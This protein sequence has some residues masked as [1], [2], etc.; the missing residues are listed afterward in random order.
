MNRLK[1]LLAWIK[2][3]LP[4]LQVLLR[5]VWNVL[6]HNW[7]FKLL[8]LVMAAVLWAGLISQDE[9]L[10]IPKDMDP[11]EI[12]VQGEQ[13]LRSRG[14][15]ITAGD[16]E[17]L[18]AAIRADVPQLKYQDAVGG[19]YNPRIDLSRISRPG[20]YT[21]DVTTTD[22]AAWGSVV[23]VSP[24][25]VSLTVESIDTRYVSV[26]TAVD[27]SLPEGWCLSALKPAV[28]IVGVRGPASVVSQV[29]SLVAVIDLSEVDV[30]SIRASTPGARSV[31]FTF[32]DADG[33]LID[34]GLLEVLLNSAVSK[35]IPVTYMLNR[36]TD[37]QLKPESLWTGTP[38]AGYAVQSVSPEAAFTLS[39]RRTSVFTASERY[40]RVEPLSVEGATGDVTGTV[41]VTLETGASFVDDQVVRDDNFSGGASEA[42]TV[43]VHIAPVEDT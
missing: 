8:A 29:G 43:T 31:G 26:I 32:A 7:I 17:G 42:F 20:E 6:R 12:Q 2:Q 14:L 40:Y 41:F 39:G 38:A 28:D 27:G 24:A 10:N 1:P 30:G 5:A 37:V 15:V 36:A 21:L 23:S 13:T 11:V 33:V 19:N 22:S 3:Q 4:R 25:S 18:Q 16:Y 9:N 35:D 34:G